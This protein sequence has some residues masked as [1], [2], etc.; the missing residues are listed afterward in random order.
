MKNLVH[1]G[2]NRYVSPSDVSAVAAQKSAKFRA[3]SEGNLNGKPL[4]EVSDDELTID[5]F[6]VITPK[7]GQVIGLKTTDD[8]V[9]AYTAAV[10][11]AINV[12]QD[13]PNAGGFEPE[14]APA[15]AVVAE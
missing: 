15:L 3:T 4:E 7:I 1:V 8:K 10:V 12:G 9:A 6:V 13:V 2:Y 11:N 14:E 5:A